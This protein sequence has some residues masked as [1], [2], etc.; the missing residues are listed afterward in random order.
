MIL[1]A[2]SS[3]TLPAA[4]STDETLRTCSRMSSGIGG[5]VAVSPSK[6]M[7]DSAAV[8]TASVPAY[9]WTKMRSKARSIASVR[10]SVPLIIDTPRTIAS[11]VRSAR[12]FR[13]ARPLSATR[14]NSMRSKVFHRDDQVVLGRVA[15]IPHDDAVG[16]KE[17]A[18]RHRSHARIVGNHHERLP[19]IGD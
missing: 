9:D 2:V 6:L 16:E 11:A 8:T 17:G 7:S 1:T 13:P 10:T 5:A 15:E 3:K 18:I 14:V 4:A 19:V 12:S